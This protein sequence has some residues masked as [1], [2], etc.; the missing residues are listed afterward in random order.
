M[1]D[2]IIQFEILKQFREI[3]E[4]F[5]GHFIELG[6]DEYLCHQGRRHFKKVG[7][8]RTES[9]E[10]RRVTRFRSGDPSTVQG[11]SPSEAENL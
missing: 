4:R 9:E 5:Q 11:P 8:K 2:E 10:R 1:H 6:L 3:F 7:W